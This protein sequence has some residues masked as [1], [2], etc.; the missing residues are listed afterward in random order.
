MADEQQPSDYLR[1]RAEAAELLGV[2]V[3]LMCASDALRVDLAV[4]L[5]RAVDSAAEDMFAGNQ[6][7]IARL[8]S[9]TEKLIDLL[10]APELPRPVS[11][12]DDPREKM[13]QIYLDMRRRGEISDRAPAPTLSRRLQEVE[14]QNTALRAENARLRGDIEQPR[15]AGG[16][17]PESDVDGDLVMSVSQPTAASAP[18]APPVILTDAVADESWKNYITPDGEIA[19]RPFGATQ[20]YWGPV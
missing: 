9:A 11:R 13:L 4:V 15:A 8:V 18:P 2:D 5:R 3:E 12:R 1:A 20:K 19:S 10:P 6:V 7:D 17:E 14:Q 16:S